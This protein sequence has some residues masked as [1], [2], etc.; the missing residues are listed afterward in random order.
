MV[1]KSTSVL[2]RYPTYRMDIGI[3]VHVQLNT[4]SK[5]FCSC[6][7]AQELQ[8]NKNICPVCAG[9]PG[10]LPVLN[11]QVV[12]YAI[13]AGLGT[14]CE[15]SLI[16]E[17]D[18]KHYF[19]PDLPKN[20]QITQNDHP[21]CRNGYVMIRLEDGR[22]KKIRINRIHIEE[23]AGKNTHSDFTGESFVDLNRTGTPLIEIVTEPDIDNAEEA[24]AYL[25]ALRTIMQYVKVSTCNM[26]EGSFRADTNLS[27]RLKTSEILGTRCELKNINSFKF[28]GDAI[29]YE[30]ERQ[31]LAVMNNERIVQE[32]RLWDSKNR[33]SVSMRKKEGMADYRFFTDP[34]LA[35]VKVTQEHLDELKAQF[36]EMPFAKYERYK[37][38][39]G[40]SDYEAD[41]ITTDLALT[42]YFEELMA[43]HA[44]KSCVNWLLR[45]V[46]GS[47]KDLKNSIEDC[48]VTPVKLATLVKLVEESVINNKAAK[49]IFDI[50]AVSGGDIQE[51]IES[52]GLKQ[53]GS[54]DELEAIVKD[55]LA[56]N[57][58]LVEEYRS[59]KQN[60]FGF[61]VGTCMK[62][63]NGNGDPKQLQA[64]LKKL[65]S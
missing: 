24:R 65:L 48:K 6:S 28:I 30:A 41:I 10:V 20:Y 44:S 11:K 63:T 35:L 33:V 1:E 4:K 5:I 60:L 26:E 42:Q 53:V 25:K 43:C 15:V 51:I 2:D 13:L 37:Q 22:V 14:N 55:I 21:I 16:S 8:P 36:P 39:F 62:A 59:G 23:D 32:T 29:E 54:A 40:L 7:N 47:L 27:V 58:A 57:A 18:R 3:E 19:Y 9:Y 34:D 31:I 45:D 56:Q 61:F 64:L 17:F 49:E 38:E 46:L 52:K 12:E 50:V